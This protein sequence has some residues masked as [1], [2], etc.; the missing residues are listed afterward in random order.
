[1]INRICL[2]FVSTL[3]HLYFNFLVGSLLLIFL[4]FFLC[5]NICFVCFRAVSF[6]QVLPVFLDCPFLIASQVFFNVYFERKHNFKTSNA[7]SSSTLNLVYDK[8]KN[9]WKYAPQ[10]LNKKYK[11]HTFQH[12]FS[13]LLVYN[14]DNYMDFFHRYLFTVLT[15]YT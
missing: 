6:A 1:M 8:K 12:Y 4:A 11:I 3:V 7:V 2:Y 10:K 14:Q 5:C 13:P 15:Q 9:V